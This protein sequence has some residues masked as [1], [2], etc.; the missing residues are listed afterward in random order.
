MRIWNIVPCITSIETINYN[1]Y[2]SIFLGIATFVGV[3]GAAAAATGIGALVVIGIGLIAL[4]SEAI[5][6]RV[7]ADQERKRQCEKWRQWCSWGK[8][9]FNYYGFL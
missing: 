3:A 5:R 8:G 9:L 6:G 1:L 7:R 4:I 2:L